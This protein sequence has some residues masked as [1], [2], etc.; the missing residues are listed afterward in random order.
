LPVTILFKCLCLFKRY[1]NA[2]IW[3]L[4]NK[5]CIF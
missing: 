4:L 1:F 3:M 2:I 5:T